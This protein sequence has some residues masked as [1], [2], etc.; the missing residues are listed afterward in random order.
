MRI[1]ARCIEGGTELQF[2]L[3]V[4]GSGP[5]GIAIA[6]RLR[7][8]G[9]RIALIESGGLDP[10]LGTQ[11]L[12]RGENVG[13]PYFNLATCRHRL[14]GGSSLA[15]GGM[16]RPL[17]PGDFE[18][19]D[20]IA[21][22]GWPISSADLEPLYGD[23]ARLLELPSADFGLSSWT[24]RVPAPLPLTGND[25]KPAIYLH[26]PKTN[27]GD[28]YGP[29]LFAA[30]DVTVLLHANVT[31]I[32]LEGDT[33]RVSSLVIRTLT[34]RSLKVNAR[35]VVLAT[36]GIENARMLLASRS[37]RSNGLGNESDL[38][39]RCFMEH[40]HVA[41]GHIST[42]RP[43]ETAF[44]EKAAYGDAVVKGV[45]T[46]TARALREHRM[47]NC[48]IALETW[49]HA[50][51]RSPALGWSPLLTVAP[52]AAYR[53]LRRAHPAAAQRLWYVAHGGWRLSRA[54][55]HSAA[56]LDLS[57]RYRSELSRGRHAASLYFRSEQTPNRASRVTLAER[58]DALG[59]PLPRLDWRVRDLDRNGIV[60]WLETFDSALREA[61]LGRV[62]M[63]GD[64][65]EP[66]V[67]GGPHHMGTTRM[68][69]DP[70]DG[71]V[72]EHCRV[73]SLDNLYVAGSS[74]FATSGYANPTFT[75]LALALRLA[76]H[77][78]RRF[79][80][81]SG[82]RPAVRAGSASPGT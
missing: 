58:R 62:V 53:R 64:G 38:V 39:G 59:V 63:P 27:F 14:F 40:L 48:S 46:P 67:I 55:R 18:R 20:W 13:D 56:G 45:V 19:R 17:D 10:E 11:Q 2:D 57:A 82:S 54:A 72:D 80:A 5:A 9:L 4:V 79:D 81:E 22:S 7:G 60:T 42:D 78:K 68:S 43:I 21:D 36:G 41:A 65:W 28:R 44:F 16:C 23:V 66:R 8:S 77:L 69:A 47:P 3:A 30:N 1:D 61:E 12:Y 50:I 76:D 74:A 33:P 6:D 32:M 70:R 29:R 73:H 35:A 51:H 52:S 15:W 34:G 24:D 26:S 71:V 25:F 49:S 31:G 75:L 37:Q